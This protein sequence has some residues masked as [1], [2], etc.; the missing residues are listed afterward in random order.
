MATLGSGGIRT[1]DIRTGEGDEDLS[2]NQPTS[3]PSDPL[4]GVLPLDHNRTTNTSQMPRPRS[5]FERH[6]PLWAD[7]DSGGLA[8][9]DES[10][11]AVAR[12]NE[13]L[14]I[15]GTPY[16]Q[17]AEA[18]TNLDI[19]CPEI[20]NAIQIAGRDRLVL[21][22]SRFTDRTCLGVDACGQL[23]DGL[24]ATTSPE[25][26]CESDEKRHLQI[27]RMHLLPFS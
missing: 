11:I 12:R 4:G 25:R 20:C 27:A 13:Q 18:A 16:E 1:A 6:W 26:Q 7:V 9:I 24:S 3:P 22:R 17:L 5:T 15:G 23:M 21:R 14:T 2:A 8:L 19:L 10:G